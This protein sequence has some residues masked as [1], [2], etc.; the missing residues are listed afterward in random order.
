MDQYSLV[1]ASCKKRLKNEINP[2]DNEY[3][4]LILKYNAN[5]DKLVEHKGE[6]LEEEEDGT[7]V[8]K[9]FR[10]QAQLVRFH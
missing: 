6:T 4:L 1:K 9:M 7:I 8:E 2:N 5:Q 10:I 3:E